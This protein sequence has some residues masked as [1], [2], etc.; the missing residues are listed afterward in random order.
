MRILQVAPFFSPRLGGSPQVVYQISKELSNRGHSV[1]VLAGDYGIN[2]AAFPIEPYKT[3]IIPSIISKWGFYFTPGMIRWCHNHLQEFDILHLHEARTFQNIVVRW[4]A[5]RY[6]IPFVL[7][8]HGT[9]PIIVQRQSLKRVYDILFGRNNLKFARYLVAV[10]P[11]EALQYKQV[12]IDQN[13]IRTIYNGINLKEFLDLPAKG[14]FRSTTLNLNEDYKIILYLGRL[15]RRK[16]INFLIES[17]QNLK[18]NENIHKF[19]LVIVGPDEGEL[20]NLQALTHKLRLQDYVR[21]IGPLYG[22]ERLAALRDSDVLA[23]PAVYEIFGLV[24]FEALMCGTPI[25]VADDCGLGQLIKE[26]DAGFLVP[27][28]DVS[29]LAN[30]L[31]YILV[32]PEKAKQKVITGQEF[33][34]AHLDWNNIVGELDDL[35]QLCIN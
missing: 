34:R 1:T 28:G 20:F 21:F 6:K 32:N 18:I 19:V 14:T 7:S 33:I 15:H 11:I 29:A 23:Y 17:L 22:K 24:P 5:T 30:S 26:A 4:F 8:A 35:Y 12:G 25:I 3:V 10:S 27:Y 2:D 9:L 13:R 31:H 16:G